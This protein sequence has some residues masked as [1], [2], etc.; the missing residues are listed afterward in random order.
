MHPFK[1]ASLL[2]L[3]TFAGFTASAWEIPIGNQKVDLH[4]FGSQG[5]LYSSDYNYLGKTTD[6]SFEYNEFGLNATI[7]PFKRTR[8]SVQGFMFDVGNVGNYNPFLDY[9]SLEYTFSDQFGVRGGRVRRPGGIYNHIQD[10]DLART[11]VLLPQ[12]I[13]DSRWR[14]FS[15]SLDGGSVFGSFSLGKAGSLS[16]EGFAGIMRLSDEGGI[17]RLLQSSLAGVGTVNGFDNFLNSGVQLW[18]NTPINGLRVGAHVNRSFEFAYD[19]TVNTPL[20]PAP[21]RSESDSIQQQYSIEY[22]WNSWTFQAEYYVL[23]LDTHNIRNIPAPVGAQVSDTKGHQDAWYVGAAYRFNPWLEVGSYYTEFY[24]SQ[25]DR[26]ST[27]DS[28]QKDLALSFRFDPKDWWI[29]KLEGHYIRGTAL[30]RDNGL[31]PVRDD[32]GWWML[33][34]KTTFSF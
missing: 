22:V 24:P 3:A 32:N 16:Y 13:Y 2:G 8:I 10:V 31:N 12:G 4:G 15:T 17:A 19:Y 7:S 23:A 25:G 5:F 33:A 9:A 28:Y 18:W 20:G 29:I 27:P 6:G 26:S 34:V 11:A 14:D 30:L 21:S 1:S